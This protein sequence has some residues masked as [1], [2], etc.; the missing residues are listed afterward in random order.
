MANITKPAGLS[1]IWADT[2]TKVDPGDAKVSIGWVVQLPK[3][4]HQNWID[5]R[6][7]RAIAHFSQHGIPE[8]DNA[9]EY[10]GQLSYTQGSNGIIYKCLQTNT[11]K[12]PSNSL[13]SAYWQIAFESYGSVKVVSDAL[14]AHILNY[15]TLAGVGNVAAARVNLSV[16]SRAESDA[17]FASLNGSASQ[18]FSVAEATQPQHA[19]RLSQV[20]AII[21]A[22]TE[23]TAGVI[24][25]ATT[26][27]V[28]TGTDNTTALTPLKASNVYLKK[29]GNL[30]GLTNVATARSN[31]GLGTMATQNVGSFLQTGNN[32]ADVPDKAAARANLGI[33]PSAVVP[34]GYYLKTGNNLGD[35][36]DKAAARA[37]LGVSAIA[38]Y[39]PSIFMYRANN[40]FDV[41]N[42]AQARNALG[43]AD[44]AVLGSGTWLRTANNLGD[45]PNKQA[46]RNNLELGNLATMNAFGQNG[47]NLDFTSNQADFGWMN[48]P[49]GIVECWG[50]I[51][52]EG[53]GEVSQLFPKA[54]PRACW[55]IQLTN[56]ENYP[57]EGNTIRV[58][59]W[60]ANGFTVSMRGNGY[61]QY[62]FRA[63]GN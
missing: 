5:N 8:W 19:V 56:V 31:L 51:N 32:L 37:N 7:D 4:E 41:A 44:S 27:A 46:A 26:G 35:V 39:D 50:R 23:S 43:L 58:R 18:V 60:D 11:N 1:N 33:T 49:N 47:A 62:F 59:T 2:G 16:Y 54:F 42:P 29:S 25:I 6:Q 61:T 55:N 45:L 52:I 28:E 48:H 9:T 12:D 3:Y 15:Q 14:A 10:Q 24:K 13:N 34:D 38:T 53:S 22:A 30:A 57:N 20:A 63:I 21:V 17:R 40:L 36:P